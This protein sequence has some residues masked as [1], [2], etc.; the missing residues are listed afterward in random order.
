MIGD[1]FGASRFIQEAQIMNCCP[2]SPGLGEPVRIPLQCPLLWLLPLWLTALP[3][4]AQSTVVQ[5]PESRS[6]FDAAQSRSVDLIGTD[7]SP[8]LL[9]VQQA[10]ASPWPTTWP[11]DLQLAQLQDRLGQLGINI[12]VSES[13]NDNSL[14]PKNW[15]HLPLRQGSIDENL[16]FALYPYQCDYSITSQGTVEIGSSDHFQDNPARVTFDVSRIPQD[17]ENLMDVIVESIDPGSWYENG[18]LGRVQL[19][20]D[21]QRR[22]LVISN[23]YHNLRAV[24]QQLQTVASMSDNRLSVSGWQN[25][26]AGIS[27]PVELPG[28]YAHFADPGKRNRESGGGFG[29]GGGAGLGGGVF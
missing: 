5:S 21:R 2:L 17:P 7:W 20:G 11:S 6:T 9:A 4:Q 23:T 14:Q 16:R 13:V 3:L 27:R 12:R 19:L 18:G 22:L 1:R 10:L 26:T 28:F 25:E 8:R 24:Q 15:L 29:G